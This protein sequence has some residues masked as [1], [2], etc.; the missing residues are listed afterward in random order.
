[1]VINVRKVSY[2]V[3]FACSVLRLKGNGNSI[4]VR[5]VAVFSS[6]EGN[7]NSAD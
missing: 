5:V 3:S 6:P 2:Q 4:S 7:P 1:V